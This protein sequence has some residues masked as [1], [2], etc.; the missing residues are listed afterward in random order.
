MHV[1]QEICSVAVE[2]QVLQELQEQYLS[3][4]CATSFIVLLSFFMLASLSADIN[5]VDLL[6]IKTKHVPIIGKSF[7]RNMMGCLVVEI[8]CTESRNFMI[9]IKITDVKSFMGSLLLKNEFDS[10]LTERAEVLMSF[11]VSL[12]GRRNSA[13][14]D[15]D[16]WKER[17]ENNRDE[18]MW[19]SWGELKPFVYQFIKGKRTPEHMK[20]AFRLSTNRAVELLEDFGVVKLY[21]E[22]Q[23]ALLFQL[24][25]EHE[26]LLLVTGI[27]Y[28]GFIMDKTIERAWDEAF[29]G[30]LKKQGIFFDKVE[31]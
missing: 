26:E 2:L 17:S 7:G 1:A 16:D 27:S 22:Q 24:R 14:Y 5:G 28:A 8:V 18:A 31:G 12:S 21:R 29:A 10:F 15:T 6:Y 25:Y 4:R 9:A 11:E 19:M 20:I 3:Q 13:W 30:Y 23:P